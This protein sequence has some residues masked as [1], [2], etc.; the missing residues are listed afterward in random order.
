MLF[1][2]WLLFG[3]RLVWGDTEEV[4]FTVPVVHAQL[5]ASFPRLSPKA[6]SLRQEVKPVFPSP[7][8]PNGTETWYELWDLAP[9]GTYEVRICWPATHPTEFLLD[10]F[11]PQPASKQL[12]ATNQRLERHKTSAS[13]E[14]TTIWP[15]YV[16][17]RRGSVLEKEEGPLYL[18]VLTSAAFYTHR[19]D[20][21]DSPQPVPF[22][23]VLERN[24]LGYIPASLTSLILAVVVVLLVAWGLVAPLVYRGMVSLLLTPEDRRSKTG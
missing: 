9:G 10:V 1:L 23:L 14:D 21:M 19:Q 3:C 17:S 4:T 12:E 18:R 11:E 22:E 5:A 15:H 13:V 7:I 6:P 20:L 2:T 8:W 16:Q 24:L